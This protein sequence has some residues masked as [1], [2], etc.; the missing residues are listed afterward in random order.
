MLKNA[1]SVIPAPDQVEGKLQQGSSDFKQFWI[2]ASAGMT[3]L[4][5]N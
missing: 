1:L 2:L 3:F 5:I 4:V